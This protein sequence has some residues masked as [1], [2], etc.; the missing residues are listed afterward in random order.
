M[1]RDVIIGTGFI[2]TALKKRL[3]E[4]GWY[5][6]KDTKVIYYLD[7]P[8]HI[9]FEKNPQFHWGRE[10]ANFAYLLNYCFE[11]K[12]HL[13]YTSSALVYEKNTE[14]TTYKKKFES[15]GMMYQNTLGCRIF[16]VYGSGENKTVISKWCREIKDGKRPEIYGDGSQQRDFIYIDDVVEH[17]ADLG[18]LK[19]KGLVDI[20]AGK[21]ISFNEI[22]KIINRV[23]K[24]DLPPYYSDAP[25]GYSEGI[26]CTNPLPVNTSIEEGIK[27]ICDSLS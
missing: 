7:G 1:A 13:I 26:F 23:L 6:E 11:N 2:A 16:P 18:K 25:E 24:K 15:L 8:T 20:G 27:K 19:T 4:Y 17:L 3:G 21:P 14:F 12:I 10:L 22:V 5:P 9:D